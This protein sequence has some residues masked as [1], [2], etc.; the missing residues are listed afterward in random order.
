MIKRVP[1]NKGISILKLYADCLLC[2]KTFHYYKA[3]GNAKF[4]SQKCY[5]TYHRGENHYNYGRKY[6]DE[7]R[8]KLSLAQKVTDPIE[9]QRMRERRLTSQR[10]W[11]KKKLPYIK[12]LYQGMKTRIKHNK[13]YLNRKILITKEEFIKLALDSRDFEKLYNKW[14]KD[15]YDLNASPSVDRI[16][17]SGNYEIKNIQFITRYDNILKWYK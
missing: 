8:L 17:N 10:I 12:G 11:R 4:C 5:L 6:S 14:V 2:G 9:L 15:G 13:T 16:N 1:W 3:R 7:L